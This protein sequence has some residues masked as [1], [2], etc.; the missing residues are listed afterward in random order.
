M[1]DTW[2]VRFFMEFLR[3]GFDLLCSDLDV[4]WLRDPRPYLIGAA[5]TSLL[6]L[7]DVV[8][9]TDVTNGGQERDDRFWGMSGE[10]NTGII[11]LRSSLASLA[12]CDEWIRR[13]QDEMVHRPPPSGGFLQWWSNDQTFFNE[14]VHRAQSIATLGH[15]FKDP[16]K[17]TR[18]AAAGLVKQA[19]TAG[20]VR[21]KMFDTAIAHVEALHTAGETKRRELSEL[22]APLLKRMT[23]HLC[24]G[25][26]ALLTIA[27]L[28]F[29]Y[30][31]SGHTFFTQSLQE[32]MGFLPVCV[33]TTFQFG[34]TA[35]F[36]WGK[37]S[38][39]REKQ[40]WRVDDDGY[41]RR[42]GSG[43]HPAEATYEGFLALTG[44]MLDTSQLKDVGPLRRS[45]GSQAVKIEGNPTFV[46][47]SLGRKHLDVFK[48][49]ERNPNRHLL[50][51]AVQRRL[52]HN[53]MALGRALRRK[54]IMPKMYCWCDR[55]WNPMF[56]CR[57]PGVSAEQ[58]PLPF[59]CPFDHVY[60]LEKWMH[61][62]A[63]FREYSF[64]NNS[65]I[66][67]S[68]RNDVVRLGVT[69]ANDG[70]G[71]VPSEGE[72]AVV[73]KPGDTYSDAVDAMKQSSHPNPYVIEITARSLELLCED[74]GHPDENAKFNTV[75]HTVLGVA[76]QVRYCDNAENPSY[77]RGPAA[78]DEWHNPINCT[79]GFHRPPVLPVH[80]GEGVCRRDVPDILRERWR[81]VDRK[82]DNP[83]FGG[84]QAKRR[85]AWSTRDRPAYLVK[86]T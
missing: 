27:T 49:P 30:F 86:K 39:L 47:Q 11:L 54:V 23:C 1:R 21:A 57:M 40:L 53:A 66:P 35:E 14:V 4:V 16:R 76:E 59:H 12:L 69:G 79:W 37:R 36:T 67:L 52:V 33:H 73:L 44:E 38:R 56:D 22:R 46:D 64:L 55:F 85:Q 5:G 32:R 74:M 81:E 19:A 17:E 72:R 34:D 13:M 29:L 41:Y 58:L 25:S 8:V 18:D 7:A 43:P 62:D 51:D 83:S 42:Q 9:S 48:M 77:G 80:S 78:Y 63:P 75:M 6:P 65:R 82:W 68:D 28:P 26:S 10:L 45:E 84:L 3:A 31:A 60:D 71:R 15:G 61:S 24:T 2:Q 20:G 70:S 50:I